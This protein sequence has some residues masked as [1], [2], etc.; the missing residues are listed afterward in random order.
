MEIGK[1]SWEG[2][3]LRHLQMLPGKIKLSLCYFVGG[4]CYLLHQLGKG[5]VHIYKGCKWNNACIRSQCSL[6]FLITTTSI[7]NA[8]HLLFLIGDACEKELP[9]SQ[10]NSFYRDL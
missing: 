9:A 8:R 2:Y 5:C 3:L 7:S 10:Y 6:K 1:A 4:E